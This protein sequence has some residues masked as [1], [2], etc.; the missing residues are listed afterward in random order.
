MGNNPVTV[1]R[2]SLGSYPSRNGTNAHDHRYVAYS[3]SR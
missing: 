3:E 2:I 1:G